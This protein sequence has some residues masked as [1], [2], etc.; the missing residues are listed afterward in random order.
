MTLDEQSSNYSKEEYYTTWFN[1]L[2]L[3]QKEK[4]QNSY[5]QQQKAQSEKD[6]AAKDFTTAKKIICYILTAV[7]AYLIYGAANTALFAV[8]Y[9]ISLL[10]IVIYIGDIIISASL[11]KYYNRP[12]LLT[13][14]EGH[15]YI[16]YMYFG[17]LIGMTLNVVI[18]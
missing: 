5:Y 12:D 11:C 1:S 13:I 2:N 17:F 15:Y 3:E 16:A 6:A 18:I 14:L 8:A 4:L 9:Y 7:T 10:F